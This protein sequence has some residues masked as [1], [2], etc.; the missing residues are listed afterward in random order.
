MIPWQFWFFTH[1]GTIPEKRGIVLDD[2]VES[3]IFALVL[4]LV[5]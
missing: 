5:V 4:M 3:I 2:F 1:F